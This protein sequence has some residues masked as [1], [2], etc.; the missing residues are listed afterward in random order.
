[1]GTTVY[2]CGDPGCEGAHVYC[3]SRRDGRDG[4]VYLVINN[5]LTEETVVELPG[6][7]QLYLLSGH[8]GL[9]AQVMDLNGTPLALAE[10]GTLPALCGKPVDGAVTLAPG[11]CAFLV[12]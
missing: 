12:L 6:S 4:C 2:D 8:G 1:M 5:S 9:R 3:R 11:S 10:D 7:A